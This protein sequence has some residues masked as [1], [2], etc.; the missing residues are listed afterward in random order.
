LRDE[1]LEKW[2]DE[3]YNGAVTHRT[4][5]DDRLSAVAENWRIDR[6]AVVDRNI[7][8]LGVY[9]LLFCPETPFS[10]AINEALE[11]AKRYVPKDSPTFVNG[12]LDRLAS[13][14]PSTPTVPLPEE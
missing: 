3:L 8:R 9:E 10:V 4:E 5:I 1:A 14:R 13:S 2:G 12:L 7:L 6:M 11:L